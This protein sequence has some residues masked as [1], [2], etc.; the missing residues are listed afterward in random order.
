MAVALTLFIVSFLIYFVSG[1]G[2]TP[3][4]FQLSQANNI[5]HG[6]LD[7][8]EEYTHNLNVLERVL[9][10]GTGF[11]LPLND[12]RGPDIDALIPNA[13]YSADCKHYMQHA[14][15]PAFMLVP[16]VVLFGPDINQTLISALVGAFTMV[17][18]FAITRRFASDL[19]TQ[20]ALTV[21]A[22]FGTTMWYSAADGSVWHFAHITSVMFLFAAI[23]A[24]VDR[25]NA[26]LAGVFIGVAFT[27]RP[28]TLLAGVFPLIAFAD[29]WLDS[30]PGTPLVRRINF[31]PL[32]AMGLGVAPFLALTGTVDYLRFGNPFETGYNLSEQIYQTNLAGVYDQGIFALSYIP[33][34]IP[35]VFEAMPN[36]S[37]QG[38][39]MWPS[40]GG[41]A[42]W[43][44]SPAL[45]LACFVHLR[46]YR[47]AALLGAAALILAGV[48][49][50]IAAVGHGLQLTD[51]STA[52][53]PFALHLLPFWLLIGLAIALALGLRDRLAIAAWA[54]VVIIALGDWMFAAT[55]WA[56]FGY[57]YGLDFIPFLWLLAVKAVPRVR[58]HHML[59][60]GMSVVM[61]LWGVL[62]VFKFAPA[63][64]FGW[65]WTGW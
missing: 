46:R 62:W 59:L 26:L 44:I 13:R 42:L 56:Q 21:L 31:R 14:L 40:Y 37:T 9:Y 6:H 35:V 45:L 7:M 1:P 65:T 61:N 24:T 32:L 36:F 58:W 17:V 29:M 2:H 34:H 15:G 10:D 47:P 16:L 3:Y 25:R 41:T 30:S 52:S 33:R 20:L 39:F 48:V 19:R 50:L 12:P 38:S 53:L 49:M 8:T 11:C 4:D 57:R 22:A 51:W 55:G 54:A 18:I 5:V 28:S 63:Q 27:C 60:I 23:W 64:F 43:V